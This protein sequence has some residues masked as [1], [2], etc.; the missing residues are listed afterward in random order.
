MFFCFSSC[1][2]VT[3]SLK[4][5]DL[6]SIVPTEV[7]VLVWPMHQSKKS[8]SAV[9]MT[10]KENEVLGSQPIPTRL[11]YA[12]D[13]LRTMSLPEGQIMVTLLFILVIDNQTLI[14]LFCSPQQLM[15]R[16]F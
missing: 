14:S 6:L 3:L 10:R 8:I 16:L 7:S 5:A 1:S 11:S 9:T 12:E 2:K 4:Y 13:A 15:R